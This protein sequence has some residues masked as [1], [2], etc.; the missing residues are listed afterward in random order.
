MGLHGSEHHPDFAGETR[1]WI[2]GHSVQWTV[3]VISKFTHELNDRLPVEAGID[4]RTAAIEHYHTVR[5]LLGGTGYWHADSDFWEDGQK[6][7]QL[8]DRFDYDNRNTVDWLGGFVQ[9]RYTRGSV[10]YYGRAG[11]STIL[12]SY[13]D[14]FRGGSN[15]SPY[16]VVR[17]HRRLLG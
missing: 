2:A 5:D 15:A 12:Y 7:W 11:Y 8:G 6:L 14:R 1:V 10:Y 16:T 9:G 17:P 3:G 4:W 13:E